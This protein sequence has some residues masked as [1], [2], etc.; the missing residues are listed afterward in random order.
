M[1]SWRPREKRMEILKDSHA[2]AFAIITCTVYFFMMYGVLDMVQG[3]LVRIYVFT[4]LLSRSF[5]GFSVVTFPKASA[6]GTV[7]GF[8]KNAQTR[9]IQITCVIYVLLCGAGMFLLHPVYGT[10]ML[11]GAA[12]AFVWYYRMAMKNFG[13]INGD[14]AGCYLSVSE[15]VMPFALVIAD[16]V[17]RLW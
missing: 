8:A 11:V 16:A 12:L 1:S 7:A 3:E 2:G 9:I 4:F 14:L 15:L 6:K 13:G 5:S 17:M 10:A